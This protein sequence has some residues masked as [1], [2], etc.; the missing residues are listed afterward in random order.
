MGH[1]GQADSLKGLGQI[2]QAIESY[3][4]VIELDPQSVGQV[5]MKRGLLYLQL[6]QNE[7]ALKDFNALTIMAEEHRQEFQASLSKAYFYKAK[8]LKKMNNL[9]DSVIY[10][11]QVLRLNEDDF[12]S[13]SSLYEIA[14]IKIMQKDF[15]EAN[16]NLQR[17]TALG[18]KQKKLLNYKLFAEGVIF[19]MK[20]KTKTGVKL[21]TQVIDR[22]RARGP[23]EDTENKD[24]A[25]NCKEADSQGSP[26]SEGN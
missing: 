2:E 5:L 13:G 16:Y 4:K 14:K 10:F 26:V 23:D 6:K 12:L 18:L 20:R 15:Y 19:L 25:V 7:A 8:A 24:P 21:L 22:M 1:L 17:S 11:E 9:N 3:T